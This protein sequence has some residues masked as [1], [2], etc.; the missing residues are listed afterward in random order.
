MRGAN[1]AS[2]FDNRLRIVI[3]M[4]RPLLLLPWFLFY[5]IRLRMISRWVESICLALCRI[6]IRIITFGD[7]TVALAKGV[8]FATIVK[9]LVGE[10]CARIKSRRLQVGL[11]GFGRNSR[12]FAVFEVAGT[13]AFLMVS[14]RLFGIMTARTEQL[15]V[16]HT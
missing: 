10:C 11:R 14:G 1:R 9:V 3:S 16:S 15:W 6:V 4:L 8:I 5:S 12:V 13:K 7:V 2:L